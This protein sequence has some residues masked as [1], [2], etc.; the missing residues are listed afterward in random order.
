MPLLLC[1]PSAEAVTTDRSEC[2]S[3]LS[4]PLLLHTDVL[5]RLQTCLQKHYPEAADL[6]CHA[7][8]ALSASSA[9]AQQL[10]E[11][12]ISPRGRTGLRHKCRLHIVNEDKSHDCR[13]RQLAAEGLVL[14]AEGYQFV[15]MPDGLDIKEQGS[16]AL[17]PCINKHDQPCLKAYTVRFTTTPGIASPI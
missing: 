2:A 3:A 12:A 6:S 4:E 1:S 14:L 8:G 5:N 13:L 9:R 17:V 11:N 15:Q 10:R 16:W 7:A